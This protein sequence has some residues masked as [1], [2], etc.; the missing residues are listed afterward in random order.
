MSMAFFNEKMTFLVPGLPLIV[1]GYGGVVK[2]GG[3]S[4][5][6]ESH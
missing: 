5:I 2:V 6:D 3:G 4:R 1:G